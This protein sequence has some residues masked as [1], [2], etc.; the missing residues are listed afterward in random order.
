MKKI[1][2][3]LPD[4]TIYYYPSF[5]DEDFAL[6]MYASLMEN[7]P[8]RSDFIKVFGKVYPQPRLTALYANNGKSYSYSSISMKPLPFTTDL[9]LIKEKI[10]KILHVKFTTCLLNLYRDG[11]DSNGWH[12]DNEKEL[13]ENPVIASVSLGADRFFHLKHRYHKNLKTKLLLHEGSLL[14]MS[15]VTQKYW[16]HQIPKTM[17][18]VNPRINLTFRIIQ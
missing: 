11:K 9:S 12:A 1:N 2:L 15:G 13:G 18:P 17:K 3:S 8:W 10:E 5:F 14:V 4:A 7:T 6:K 16:L